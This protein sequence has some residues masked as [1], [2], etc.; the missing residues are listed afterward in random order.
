LHLSLTDA[1]PISMGA[2]L[3]VSQAGQPASAWQNGIKI[4]SNSTTNAV[5]S[6]GSMRVG[7]RKNGSQGW[8]NG[9]LA[10]VA[11]WNRVLSDDEMRSLAANPWQIF[12]AASNSSTYQ[13][14]IASAGNVAPVGVF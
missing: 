5:F 1:L 11:A 4:G 2:T 13:A 9:G 10:M 6:S 12:T 8:A 3:A 14:A 7:G